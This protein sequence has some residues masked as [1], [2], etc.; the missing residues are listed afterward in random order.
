M[1]MTEAT[2]TKTPKLGQLTKDGVYAG[3]ALDGKQEIFVMPRD[4]SV[5]MTF[6]AA[7]KA[8]KNLNLA[9]AYGHND[10]KIPDIGSLNVMQE[11]QNQGSLKGTFKTASVSDL[12]PCS[13]CYWSSTKFYNEPYIVR[14]SDDKYLSPS[15]DDDRISCRPVRLVA[16]K[17]PLLV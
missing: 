8:I 16:C 10:W 17:N 1:R 4:L 15:G 7:R 6:K 2:S 14:F 3:I 9:N 5:L 12:T 11:M 13:G